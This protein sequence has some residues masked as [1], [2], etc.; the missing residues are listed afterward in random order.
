[1]MA[2]HPIAPFI[3]THHLDEVGCFF[4]RY[5]ALDGLHHLMNGMQTEPISFLQRCV[6][7]DWE[8]K[9]TYSISLGYVV[10]VNPY[11]LLPYYLERPKITFKAWNKK[12]GGGK[13][14]FD[15]QT[16]INSHYH[17][18]LLFFLDK[19]YIEGSYA[20]SIYNHDLNFAS[21]R[22][23]SFCFSFAFHQDDISILVLSAKLHKDQASLL[24]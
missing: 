20:V 13:F 11:V 10:Q 14:D 12:D 7:Y 19:I 1:M 15:T 8:K 21:Q 16:T 22:W 5:N 6:C 3:S 9:L 4:P 18:H 17:K 24:P 2:T 23:W